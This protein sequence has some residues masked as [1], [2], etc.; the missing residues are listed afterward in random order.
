MFGEVA[1]F[2]EVPQMESVVSLSVCRILAI[3]RARYEALCQDFPIGARTVLENLKR[4]AQQVHP[5]PTFPPTC[6]RFRSA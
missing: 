2:T 5:S 3:P 4:Q 6:T 1:Y